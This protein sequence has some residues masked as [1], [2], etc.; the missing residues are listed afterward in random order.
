MAVPRS[1]I[2]H[3]AR[4]VL[5][6]VGLIEAELHHHGIDHRDERCRED[7]SPASKLRSCSR[8]R[9]IYAAAAHPRQGMRKLCSQIAART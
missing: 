4:I 3:P 7:E 2:T 9:S 8:P 5:P 6:K 1:V